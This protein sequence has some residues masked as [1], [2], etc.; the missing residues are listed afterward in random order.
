M[1]QKF[2]M[3]IAAFCILQA[4]AQQTID[5]TATSSHNM[6]TDSS[7]NQYATLYVYRPKDFVGSAISYNLHAGDS[8]IC[9]VKNNSKYAIH[10]FKEGELELWAKTEK[11]ESVK[12]DVKFGKKYYLKCGLKEGILEGRPVFELV[13]PEQGELD[14]ANVKGRKDE[15]K[16][17]GSK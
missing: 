11:R 1:K 6:L 4:K 10:L 17:D 9:K 12:I 16:D 5:S 7:G 14:F 3:L 2:F 8:E 15:N 13:I